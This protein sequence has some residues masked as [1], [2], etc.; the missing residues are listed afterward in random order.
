MCIVKNIQ[1]RVEDTM[2]EK[3][4]DLFKSLG[5]STNEA[6]KIFLQAAIN[7]DGF[8]FEVKR[9]EPV[10]LLEDVQRRMLPIS[11]KQLND[12]ELYL[13]DSSNQWTD[14]DLGVYIEN[15]TLT[16]YPYSDDYDDETEEELANAMIF[17]IN[18]KEV[19]SVLDAADSYS[20]EVMMVAEG[21][22]EELGV[23]DNSNVA[24]MD[25]YFVFTEQATSKTR[26]KIFKEYIM[27]Y[28]KSCGVKYLGFMNAGMWRAKSKD[29]QDALEVAMKSLKLQ[30]IF[31]HDA[32]DWAAQ[33]NVI[34]L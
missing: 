16:G 30:R 24:I 12:T 31:L 1:V 23:P 21:M 32:H 33:I 22:V 27:P 17:R 25:E 34:K 19:G 6:I 8:P 20:E 10:D 5:T 2:K 28:L 9:P 14:Y 26:V 13:R 7:N 18:G 15:L 3:A 4:D 29:A 11:D